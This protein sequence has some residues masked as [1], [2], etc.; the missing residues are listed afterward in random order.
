MVG[1]A[2]AALYNAK[3]DGRNC[4]RLATDP[5]PLPSDDRRPSVVA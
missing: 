4:V 1:R 2:D 3:Q 5:V